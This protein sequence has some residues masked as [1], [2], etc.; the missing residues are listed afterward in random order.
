MARNPTLYRDHRTSRTYEGFN[1]DHP[2]AGFYRHRMRSGGAFVGVRIWYGQPLDP[3]TGEELDR[4]PRWQAHVN[5][6]YVELDR[7]WPMCARSPIDEAEYRHLVAMQDWA[8]VNA[9]DSA[10]ADPSRRADPLS[11]P[12]LF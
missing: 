12:M 4:S 11:T 7:V 2:V 3:V 8:K 10:L 1:V 9:P 5:D 6:C